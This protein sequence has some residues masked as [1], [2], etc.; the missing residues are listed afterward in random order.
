MLKVQ[1]RMHPAIS[2]FP[3]NTFYKGKL[4]NSDICVAR[5]EDL[6]KI[7]PYYV[8]DI[9]L[10]N[11]GSRQHNINAEEIECVATLLSAIDEILDSSK[12]QIGVITPYNSQK[13]AL[14]AK[15]GEKK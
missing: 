6:D 5:Q 11:K 7:L 8:F 14:F 1:H 12:L 15:F 9:N 3:N 10:Q 2:L 4:E 13:E